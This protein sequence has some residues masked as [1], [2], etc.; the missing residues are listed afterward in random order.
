MRVLYG[1]TFFHGSTG[2]F[3]AWSLISAGAGLSAVAPA[4]VAAVAG[5]APGTQAHDGALMPG[6]AR[7]VACMGS[8]QLGRHRHARLAGTH[9]HHNQLKGDQAGDVEGQVNGGGGSVPE[10]IGVGDLL[11]AGR[12]A[13]GQAGRKAAGC[14]EGLG[15]HSGPGSRSW[16]LPAEGKNICLACQVGRPA[17]CTGCSLLPCWAAEQLAT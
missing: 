14:E 12:A 16:V 6:A 13:G 17:G 1:G 3:R 2:H 7:Q 4:V 15:L 9:V 5:V 10:H 8:G 11:Q